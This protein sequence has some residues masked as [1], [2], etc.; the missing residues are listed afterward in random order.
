LYKAETKEPKRTKSSER[1]F[2]EGYKD[3]EEVKGILVTE[4]LSL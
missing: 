3:R 4:N 1:Q 2:T